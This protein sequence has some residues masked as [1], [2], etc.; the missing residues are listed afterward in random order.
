M[1]CHLL[2]M[3]ACQRDGVRHP[4]GDTEVLSESSNEVELIT[5]RCGGLFHAWEGCASLTPI[6]LTKVF[7]IEDLGGVDFNAILGYNVAQEFHALQ[8]KRAL[9]EVGEKALLFESFESLADAQPSLPMKRG[10]PM[11]GDERH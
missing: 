11:K 3:R 2:Q 5:G 4:E 6:F 9:A 8:Q 1:K 7:V 10:N